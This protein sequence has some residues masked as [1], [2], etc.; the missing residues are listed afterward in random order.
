MACLLQIYRLRNYLPKLR[1]RILINNSPIYSTIPSGAPI[2]RV[3]RLAAG[4]K[5][6]PIQCELITGLLEEMNFE[7]LSYVWDVTLVPHRILV[8]KK[9]LDVTYNLHGNRSEMA[10]HVS[11]ILL[12][13]PKTFR[14]CEA[15]KVPANRSRPHFWNW[16]IISDPSQPPLVPTRYMLSCGY[17]RQVTHH[18]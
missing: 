1:T 2:I 9:L 8:N 3:I 16:Y 12:D 4:N 6:D 11:K 14:D 18:S 10:F 15:N 7:A 17:F 5:S 13:L